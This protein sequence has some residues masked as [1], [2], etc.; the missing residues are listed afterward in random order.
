[1][2]AHGD[3]TAGKETYLKGGH[4]NMLQKADGF[5]VGYPTGM[6]ADGSGNTATILTTDAAGDSFNW[7][8]NPPTY[9]PLVSAATQ[10]FWVAGFSGLEGTWPH[11]LGIG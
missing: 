4:K 1:M 7:T 9:T 6:K 5:P 3:A 2:T 11:A 10:V 8:S